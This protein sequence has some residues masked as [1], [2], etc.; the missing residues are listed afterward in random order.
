M[1]KNMKLTYFKV[2]VIISKQTRLFFVIRGEIRLVFFP[3][4]SY[5]NRDLLIRVFR[6]YPENQIIMKMIAEVH[7][8]WV[9]ATSYEKIYQIERKPL[10]DDLKPWTYSLLQLDT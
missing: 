10:A 7:Q 1:V 8:D 5:W 6:N 2:L 4:L 3:I 9:V